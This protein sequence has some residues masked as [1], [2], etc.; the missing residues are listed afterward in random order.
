MTELPLWAIYLA[1]FGTPLSALIGVLVS[2][3]WSGRRHRGSVFM[4]HLEWASEL[5][6]ASDERT[7]LFGVGQL[8]ALRRSRWYRPSDAPLIEAALREVVR[9]PLADVAASDAESILVEIIDGG[10]TEGGETHGDEVRAGGGQTEEAG[11]GDT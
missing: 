6:V 1:A 10:E 11:G 7:R 4:E 2:G 9:E 8:D 5:S 3:W